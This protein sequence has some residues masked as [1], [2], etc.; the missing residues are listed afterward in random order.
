MQEKPLRL[1]LLGFIF[2]Y[3]IVAGFYFGAKI[4]QPKLMPLLSFLVIPLTYAWYYAD[5]Q[6]RNLKR[7]SSMGAAMILATAIAVPVYLVR[8][9]PK[10]TRIKSVGKYF[11][12]FLGYFGCAILGS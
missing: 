2:A 4:P 10:G 5:S 9:R 7:S 6:K 1:T 11:S 3:A 8:S 12:I